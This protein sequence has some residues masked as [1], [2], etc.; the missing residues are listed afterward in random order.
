MDD[1]PAVEAVGQQTV[2]EQFQLGFGMY[3]VLGYSIQGCSTLLQISCAQLH[4]SS[5]RMMLAWPLSILRL[6]ALAPV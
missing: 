1:D 6:R 4:V 3:F 5:T 2:E